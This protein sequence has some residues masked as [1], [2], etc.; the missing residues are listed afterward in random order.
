MAPP[1]SAVPTDPTKPGR[2]EFFQSWAGW[3]LPIAIW[4]C[5]SL[6]YFSAFVRH[7]SRGVV[8][9]P[10]GIIYAWFLQSVEH[11]LAHG[12]NPFISPGM[13]APGGVNLMWNASL[14]LPAVVLAPLT[15]LVGGLAVAGWLMV[16]APV[17]SAG[18]AYFVLRR[19]TG[20]VVGSA[21]AATLYG[22]GP[23]F[24]GHAGHLHLTLAAPALPL[25]LLLGYRLLVQQTGSPLR[26]GI[27]LGVVVAATMLIGEEIVAIA[28][29]IAAFGV[30][31]GL[32]VLWRPA[33]E[34]V[35]FAAIGLAAAVGVAVVLLAIPLY[36]QFFGRF[37][38]SSGVASPNEPLDLI[39]LFRPSGLQ[40]YARTSDVLANNSF[41]AN[42]IENTGYLGLPLIALVLVVV[43]WLAVRRDRFALWWV[44][45]A[46]TAV[47]LSF[48]SR[49]WVDGSPRR[50][51]LPWY[52]LKKLPLLHSTVTVRFSV[53]TLLLVALL[54]AYGL[55][56]LPAGRG[57]FAGLLVVALCLVPLRPTHGGPYDEIDRIATP[58]FFT[59]SAVNSIETGS[60]VLVLP[61]GDGPFTAQYAMYWQIRAK[62]HFRIVG[63]YG[64]FNIGGQSSYLA[65][66]P[67]V[68]ATLVTVAGT[69]LPPSAGQIAA[70]K[71]SLAPSTIRYVVIT[72][73]TQH[74]DLVISVATTITGCTPRQV[75]DVVL[76]EV[77]R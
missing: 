73:Q 20:T 35:R 32:I 7:P 59:T 69:G 52:L 74:R 41:A 24:V 62:M 28:V 55:A 68:G 21:L 40:Y 1:E 9:G 33:R 70:A 13:N 12:H 23:F 77:G 5:G 22:F 34:R 14:L 10:D 15:A 44:L 72:D 47:V 57:Y 49:L 76:C 58:R 25:V 50:I 8:G 16:L 45:T 54:L 18:T 61:N 46:G 37:A 66:L 39:S 11:S 2:T 43:G 71:V 29:V 3:L 17:L 31:A 30:I 42:G 60:T 48:G 36:Y 67:A 27:W 56:R 4:T 38:L 65:P 19:L 51:G 26:I 75:S 53:V 63:G 6:Y 64:V